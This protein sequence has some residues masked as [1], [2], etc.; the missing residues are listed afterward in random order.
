MNQEKAPNNYINFL[1]MKNFEDLFERGNKYRKVGIN[2]NLPDYLIKNYN[3]IK[4]KIG[5]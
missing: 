1:T 3:K 2:E 5:L 4:E